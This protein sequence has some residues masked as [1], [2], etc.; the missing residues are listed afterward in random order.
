MIL[1][2]KDCNHVTRSRGVVISRERVNLFVENEEE[3]GILD[4][5]DQ[6]LDKQ[7]TEGQRE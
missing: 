3:L 5:D 6:T 1:H 2:L 7:S 4:T